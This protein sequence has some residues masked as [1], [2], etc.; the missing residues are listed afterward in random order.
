MHVKMP[1]LDACTQ[2]VNEQATPA[3]TVY[4]GAAEIAK[5]VTN[6]IGASLEVDQSVK[7]WKEGL[8]TGEQALWMRGGRTHLKL[9]DGFFDADLEEAKATQ[10]RFLIKESQ[11]KV[12]PYLLCKALMAVH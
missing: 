12:K 2:S 4:S 8:K 3:M 6:Q 11:Y 9:A 7:L 5:F 10:K 1:G